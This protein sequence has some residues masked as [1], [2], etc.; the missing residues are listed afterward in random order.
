MFVSL[1]SARSSPVKRIELGDALDDVAEELD[2]DERL[3]GRRLELEGVATHPE[4]GAR[5][6]LVVALVLEVDQVAEDR[7]APILP[8]GPELQDGRTV[9]D[10]RPEAVDARHRGDDDDVAPLEQRVGGGVTEPIDLVVAARVLL[11]VGVAPGQVRLGL[12]VVEVADEVLDGVLG[13]E[14]AELRVQLGGQGL[15][16]GE[17]ERRLVVIGDRPGERGRLAGAG[18]AEEGLVT[19]ALGQAGAQPLDRR[20]LV[21]GRL[22]RGDELEVGHDPLSLPVGARTEHP[23]SSFPSSRGSA[24]R[25]RCIRCKNVTRHC[26]GCTNHR[27]SGRP[28]T[29]RLAQ[30]SSGRASAD[31]KDQVDCSLT[32]H[33]LDAKRTMA[34][35]PATMHVSDEM[36]S[37]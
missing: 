4:A 31:V 18:R 10:R 3:L 32:A 5:E 29:R 20:W 2:A 28:F 17:D 1:R 24:E 21:A 8:A 11:D 14:L 25:R 27:Q 9:V 35:R 13:K 12:V 7:V 37:H 26:D 36:P 30:R 23:F 19:D 33:V 22:E 15:V 34:S 6:S 16:V